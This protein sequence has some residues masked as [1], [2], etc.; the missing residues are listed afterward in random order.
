MH[1]V[2]GQVP[3]SRIRRGI[4][5]AERVAV[6]CEAEASFACLPDDRALVMESTERAIYC[7][8]DTCGAS[9]GPRRAGRIGAG[10]L[11][12]G[13]LRCGLGWCTGL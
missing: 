2:R 3:T 5:D 9:R 8:A 7:V 12:R 11:D 13:A 10:L 1:R 4:E 6:A